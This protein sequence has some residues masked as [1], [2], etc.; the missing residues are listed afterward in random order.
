MRDRRAVALSLLVGV[1]IALATAKGG[2]LA[3]DVGLLVVALAFWRRPPLWAY[4]LALPI[5]ISS[6]W[7][8]TWWSPLWT[9]ARILGLATVFSNTH[10]RI[11]LV[12]AALAVSYIT[13]TLGLLFVLGHPR[14]AGFGDN[15]SVLGQAGLTLMVLAPVAVPG[16]GLFVAASGVLALGSSVARASIASLVLYAVGTS[17]KRLVLLAG[18]LAALVIAVSASFLTHTDDRL[19][20]AGVRTSLDDRWSLAQAGSVSLFGYGY[21]SYIQRTGRLRIHSVPLIAV[22]ELGILSLPMF[23]ILGWAIW[24]R[25]IPLAFVAAMVPLWLLTEEQWSGAAGHYTLAAMTAAAIALRSRERRG[26]DRRLSTAPAQQAA[27]GSGP[28]PSTPP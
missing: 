23:G 13:Q 12:G 6:I 4:P 19:G 10:L 11:S 1:L 24:K 17:P 28:A 20:S 15:A 3:A 27:I 5:G 7:A 21:D 18:S 8:V 22:Y 25:K 16:S 26:R 14:P 2:A 9:A